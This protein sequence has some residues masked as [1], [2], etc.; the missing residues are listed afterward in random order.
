MERLR[1]LL[2]FSPTPP[3]LFLSP[4]YSYIA[5][6]YID[7]KSKMDYS[8]SHAQEKTIP[9]IPRYAVK[10]P[11]LCHPSSLKHKSHK[12][13]RQVSDLS[14]ISKQAEASSITCTAATGC[15]RVLSFTTTV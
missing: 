7:P 3:P 13:P 6:S 1:N 14:S 2:R 9:I 11:R 8:R 10:Q 5:D 4:R 12:N 15:I